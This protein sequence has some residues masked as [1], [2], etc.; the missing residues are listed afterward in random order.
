MKIYIAASWKHAHAVVML[1]EKLRRYKYQV[2]SFIEQEAKH[3]QIG[4]DA[5]YSCMV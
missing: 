3:E 1:T 2:L 5:L 4:L